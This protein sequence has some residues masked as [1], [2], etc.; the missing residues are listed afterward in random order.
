MARLSLE[1]E[2]RLAEFFKT[3]SQC[4]R[5]VE[6]CRISLCENRSFEPYSAFQHLDRLGNGYLNFLDIREFLDRNRVVMSD[7]EITQLVKQY[8]SDSDG[9]LQLTDFQQLALPSTNMALRDLAVSRTS[10]PRLSLDAEYLL[11]RLLEKECQS[12]S[13][14]EGARKDVVIRPD[15]TNLDAFKVM[16]YPS[17]SFI[18]RDK[19]LS[20]ARRQGVPLFDEDVDAI[21][22]RL[23]T[24]GDESLSYSE[25]VEALQ[26]T[27]Y[28]PASPSR[29]SPYRNSSP[30]RRSG[31][32]VRN[33][34]GSPSRGSPSRGSPTRASPSRVSGRSPLTVSEESELVSIFF[35][36]INLARDLDAVIKDLSL[37]ADFNLIDAFRMFDIDDKGYV[38]ELDFEETLVEL[39]IRPVRDEISLLF[40]HYSSTG[41]RRLRY[42]EFN[43]LFTPKD[44]EY[45]RLIRNRSPYNV[46]RSERRRV[47]TSETTYR[48]TRAM[49]I[50]LESESVAESIRQK[51]DRRPLFSLL[52]AFQ[53]VDR[54]RNGYI[55]MDEFQSVLQDHGIFA[56]KKDVESLMDRYDKDRDGRVSYSEFLNEVTPKSP[57]KY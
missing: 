24:D 29:R 26:T 11:A 4:E 52:D 16:D 21:L 43:E 36:Q 27:G 48:I 51:L 8:D 53:S 41:E 20:F 30:L 12:Q 25:F 9:R 31:S 13:R 37:R 1:T 39:G 45:A 54:D 44:P 33:S 49:Q 40:K 7:F 3:V 14:I 34:Y 15:F 5:D 42:S 47:F 23:D 22:R 17:T 2:S 38:N 50:S 46:T 6:L 19:F 56:S 18:S 10:Y 57:R 35:Q 28:S 55:T 32:P